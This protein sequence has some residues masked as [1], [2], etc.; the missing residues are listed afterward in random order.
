MLAETGA[1]IVN[2]NAVKL[3]FK[4]GSFHVENVNILTLNN[5]CNFLSIKVQKE[6]QT[7]FVLSSLL[8]SRGSNSIECV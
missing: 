2:V 7:V 3:D 4:R 6:T 5:S 8:N 1:S